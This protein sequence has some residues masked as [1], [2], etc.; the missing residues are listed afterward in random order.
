MQFNWL[1]FACLIVLLFIGLTTRTV[2]A[3]KKSEET[4]E[5]DSPATDN[6]AAADD[7]DVDDDDDDDDDNK[8]GKASWINFALRF[9]KLN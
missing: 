1:F 7:D 3:G 2:D 9:Y 6:D 5:E 8:K 4:N